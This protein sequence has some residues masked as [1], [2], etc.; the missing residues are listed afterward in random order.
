M[1]LTRRRNRMTTWPASIDPNIF[2]GKIVEVVCFGSN[3][4]SLHF[5]ERLRIVITGGFSHVTGGRR[6]SYG[7]TAPIGP[8]TLV[9]IAGSEVESG[10]VA[11]DE[12]TLRIN[13]GDEVVVHNDFG[14]E[15]YQLIVGDD[16]Y[17]V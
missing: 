13:N 4:V 16:T 12:L 14:H 10:V 1:Y 5:G 15:S 6:S 7:V 11:N 2:R 8:C 17:Y 9:N 3:S